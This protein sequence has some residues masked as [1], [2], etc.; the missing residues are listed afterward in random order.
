M[1]GGMSGEGPTS[2]PNKGTHVPR[3]LLPLLNVFVLY[4]KKADTLCLAKG[5][6]QEFCILFEG[7][8]KPTL[9]KNLK[10]VMEREE[11]V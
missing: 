11:I 6:R 10:S 3:H 5:F 1:R 8:H 7:E 9:A 4:S 2:V